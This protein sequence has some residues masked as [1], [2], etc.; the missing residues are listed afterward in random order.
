LTSANV[1]I[2]EDEPLSGWFR[3][4]IADPWG[5]R[6]ELLERDEP[7]TTDSNRDAPNWMK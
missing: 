5:N 7:Q 2:S 3:F 1:P 4:Y 6:I